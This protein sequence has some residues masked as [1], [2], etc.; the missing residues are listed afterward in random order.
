MLVQH[1]KLDS[2]GERQVLDKRD[3]KIPIE[4]LGVK[5]G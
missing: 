5:T 3:K 4:M 2:V 1:E